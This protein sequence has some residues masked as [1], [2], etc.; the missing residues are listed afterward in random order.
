MKRHL[1]A[2]EKREIY[3]CKTPECGQ[4]FRK[5]ATLQAHISSEHEG[6]SPYPCVEVGEDG[7][8]CG[9]GFDTP[10]KLKT[11]MGRIHGQDR[12]WC[13]LCSGVNEQQIQDGTQPVQLSSGEESIITL[14]QAVTE[15]NNV[16]MGLPPSSRLRNKNVGPVEFNKAISYVN[17]VK[18]S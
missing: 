16:E 7:V 5:H 6:K 10:A 14:C 12:Y 3:T 15:L 17:K 11:H 13:I 9:A 2:H 18:V 8:A 1:A 4:A